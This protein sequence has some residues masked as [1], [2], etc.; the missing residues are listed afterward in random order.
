[1]I[2]DYLSPMIASTLAYCYVGNVA[3]SFGDPF[4]TP[5]TIVGGPSFVAN[6]ESLILFNLLAQIGPEVICD[7]LCI[8]VERYW[9]FGELADEYWDTVTSMTGLLVYIPGFTLVILL[10]CGVVFL[11]AVT[12]CDEFQCV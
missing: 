3:F 2:V 4:R 9:G 8:F 5:G 1:M 7:F 11:T 6:I 12:A 10:N